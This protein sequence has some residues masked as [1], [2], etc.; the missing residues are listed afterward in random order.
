MVAWKVPYLL[1]VAVLPP[2][3]PAHGY[4]VLEDALCGF[5]PS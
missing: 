5:V 1:G 3:Y 2:I 4:P